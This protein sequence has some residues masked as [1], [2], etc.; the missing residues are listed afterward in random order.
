MRCIRNL[1]YFGIYIMSSPPKNL[2]KTSPNVVKATVNANKKTVKSQK[3]KCSGSQ[4]QCVQQHGKI[5]EDEIT[6]NV[7]KVSPQ[8]EP[9]YNSPHDIR[10]AGNKL[11][12]DV[13][14]SIKCTK[15][16]TVD[17]ASFLNFTKAIA[18]GHDLHVIVVFYKQ[19]NAEQKQITRIVRLNFTNVYHLLYG[20]VSYDDLKAYYE[21]LH[22]LLAINYEDQTNSLYKTKAKELNSKI[23][24]HGGRMLISCKVGNKVKGRAY[25]IQTSLPHFSQFLKE[26]PQII[27]EDSVDSIYGVSL[28]KTISSKPRIIKKQT[29]FVDDILEEENAANITDSASFIYTSEK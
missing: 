20:T 3:I 16:N 9:R 17:F 18:E 22:N 8:H 19:I 7:Y 1:F 15:S 25:R 24:S 13:A 23:K 6:R 28:T 12:R 5:W 10:A 14:V 26:Y 27:L 29:E 2:T 4:A 21:E 11:D